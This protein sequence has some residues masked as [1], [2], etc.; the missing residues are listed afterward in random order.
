MSGEKLELINNILI[1]FLL[2]ALLTI[3]INRHIF[4]PMEYSS[5][6]GILKVT[7]LSLAGVVLVTAFSYLVVN[8]D[9]LHNFSPKIDLAFTY[10]GGGF[11]ILLLPLLLVAFI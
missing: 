5:P 10:S 8:F 3:T 4:S 9:L 1:F 7:G 6:L 2:L 11:I